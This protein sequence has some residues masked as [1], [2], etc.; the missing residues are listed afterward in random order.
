MWNA[1]VS[2]PVYK[3]GVVDGIPCIQSGLTTKNC[4]YYVQKVFLLYCDF[5]KQTWFL[6]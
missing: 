6:D 5:E 2:L 4:Y 1:L 3:V